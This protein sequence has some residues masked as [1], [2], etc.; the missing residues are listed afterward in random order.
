MGEFKV[1][2]VRFFNYVPKAIRCITYNRQAD[3]LA[4]SRTNGAVEVYN[5]SA[6]YY[7][8]KVFPGNE[9]QSTEALCWA[10]PRLF[11]AGL[12]GDISEYDLEKL[13]IKYSLNG[14][15]GPIW[16]M[17]SNPSGTH[18]VIGCEDGSLKL[19]WV[20]PDR[21]QFK[22]NLG[23]QKGRVLSVC[24]HPLGSLIAAGSINLIRI[25]D[26]KSGNTTQRIM[27]DRRLKNSHKCGCVV[28]GV[29]FLSD[30]TVV[31]ID[32]SGKMQ[33]WN[34]A[35]GTLIQT[36][37]LSDSDILA[38]SVSE[39]ED[40]IV[41]GN[42]EGTVFHFQ[43]ISVRSGSSE[44]QW[45]RTKAFQHHTHDV[46]SVAHSQ[47]AL[48]S[49][50]MDTHL[51]I[52]PLMERVQAKNYD[53]ALRKITFPHQSLISCA[54]KMKLLLFQFPQWL[55]LWQLGATDA[56]GKHGDILPVSKNPEHLLQLKKK[57]PENI[58]CSCLSPCGSW[59]AYSTASRLHL[60]LL[61]YG[62]NNSVHLK[63]VSKVPKFHHSVHRILFSADSTK[64]FVALNE[65]SLHVLQLSEGSIKHLH[66]FHPK[67]GTLGAISLLAASADGEWLAAA[68]ASA[69]INIYS[70][71]HFKHHCTL[72]AYNFPATAMAIH[73][74]TNN[75]VVTH[76][77]QQVFEF[78]IPQ[79]QYT[80][81]SRKIQKHGFHRLWLERDTPIIHI[82]FRPEKPMHILLHDTF[83]FCL[84]DKSLPLP[85]D[86]SLLFN[87]ASLKQLPENSRKHF[88]HAFKI[89][90]KYQPLLFLDVLDEDTL[91]AVERPLE[92]IIAQLPPPIKRKKFG[93]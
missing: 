26:S 67:S 65:G 39:K 38:I 72:P 9:G 74:E 54:R 22:R 21:I 71:K 14:Y 19:F 42:A 29:A 45:I 89:S 55:E 18:L 6:N 82:A 87:Q 15:G 40:S 88:A 41:V 48:I 16:S 1:H 36:N 61:K 35:S 92:D 78:S 83:M 77:D 50:G 12:S 81:W 70:L 68:S 53:C 60:H 7:Q 20:S 17:A 66:T 27:V 91:V 37:V 62:E 85:D 47:T 44:C 56:V 2:R 10:G 46:R 24:W 11:S 28:W 25:L 59:I 30:G 5:L 34:S 31:S 3:K 23:H 52:R 73:P 84:I 93:T 32:S 33:L 79:K 57:G 43:L 64:L 58:C 69:E 86:K 8:E 63:R 13:N 4:V 90:K 51:V 49:G 75:L 76:S 80:E